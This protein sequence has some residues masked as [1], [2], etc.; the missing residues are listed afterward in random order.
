M[1]VLSVVTNRTMPSP[2]PAGPIDIFLNT[3]CPPTLTYP[4]FSNLIIQCPLFNGSIHSHPDIFTK[5]V[6]PYNTN[7]LA[8]LLDKH[9]LTTNY[10]DLVT[11]LQHGFP[12]GP[13]PKLNCTHILPNHPTVTDYHPFIDKYLQ[14]EVASGRMSGP[15]SR[16]MIE[17]ILRGPFQSSPLI[18]SVQSQGPGEPDKLRVCRHLSKSTKTTPSVNSFISKQ[19]FLTRFDTASCVANMVSDLLYPLLPLSHIL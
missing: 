4:S 5:I 17:R 14:E 2:A 15:F 1:P 10:P 8:T 9:N 18:V 11:N 7:T 13:M 16:E 12:L 3:S 19:D 6:C